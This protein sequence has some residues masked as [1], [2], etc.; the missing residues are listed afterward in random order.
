MS[1]ESGQHHISKRRVV[2]SAHGMDAAAVRRDLEYLETGAGALTFDIYRPP[3][4]KEGARTPA[5]VIVAGF[6]DTGFESRMGC[7]F[8]EMGSSVSWGQLMA[9][10]GLAAIAYTNRDPA[11][12]LHA[13]LRHVRQDA[14]ALGLD[15]GRL[16]LWASSGNVPLAL[17]V[18]MKEGG[19]FL[20]CAVLFY[21][22]TLD[23]DGAGGVAE[24]S[25][26]W[27]FANPG[28][29]R[30]VEDLPAG[31]PLFVARAGRDQMPGLNESLDRFL[32]AVLARNLPVTFANHPEGPH[33]FDLLDDSDASRVIVRLALDFMRSHLLPSL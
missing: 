14:A 10:S 12:D 7:K 17:S 4:L 2:Y 8:K 21:G 13:L 11:A 32:A 27:G 3:G 1:Q 18:L 26:T 9:A 22:Y 25:K 6:P 20:K 16:G 29:G 28:Q 19:D 23:L 5:V 24:A 31:V 33:A 15:E 30:S